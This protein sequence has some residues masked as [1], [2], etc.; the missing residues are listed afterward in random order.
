MT[1]ELILI[2]IVIAMLTLVMTWIGT[3]ICKLIDALTENRK[4]LVKCLHD[5]FDDI[6]IDLCNIDERLIGMED[7]A[8][9]W[10]KE[11]KKMEDEN[12]GEHH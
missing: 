8:T 10:V 4:V 2:A 11:N 3:V 6:D 7:A 9:Y 1:N 5:N 12:D